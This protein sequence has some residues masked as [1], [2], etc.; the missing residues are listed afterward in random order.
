MKDP[1]EIESEISDKP[2]TNG[3]LIQPRHPGP[4]L[5]TV[6][7]KWILVLPTTT[8]EQ[9]NRRQRLQA[10]LERV[11]QEFDDGKGIGED[12]VRSVIRSPFFDVPG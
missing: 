6:L 10:E 7:Q 9:R 5:W 1:V 4:N 8:E 11:V 3:P 12:G 2:D